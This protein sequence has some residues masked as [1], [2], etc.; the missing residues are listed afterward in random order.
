MQVVGLA[1]AQ[2][3]QQHVVTGHAQ[4][5][6][7]D[8]QHAGDRTAPE[9]HVHRRAHAFA[10]SLGSAHVGAYRHVHADVAGRTGQ[11]RTNG[12]ANGGVPTEE[13]ADQYE[14]HHADDG[15]GQVLA[16]EIGP[17]T[18]LDGGGDFLHAGIAGRLS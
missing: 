12:E 9:R 7:P 10:C 8:H 1:Q 4:Q 3:L 11:H 5:A 2:P 14:Q 18:F 17:R 13:D 6:E 15:D 16:V